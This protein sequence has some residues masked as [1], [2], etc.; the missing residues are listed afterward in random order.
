VLHSS[1]NILLYV[2]YK[3]LVSPLL[4]EFSLA[5][6]SLS[7]PVDIDRTSLSGDCFSTLSEDDTSLD[8]G[9]PLSAFGLLGSNSKQPLIV[10]VK[11]QGI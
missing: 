3:K 6:I 9:C 7:L 10:Q 2:A 4:D 5:H 11:K 1:A 8:P